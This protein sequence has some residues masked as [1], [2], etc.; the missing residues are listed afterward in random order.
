MFDVIIRKFQKYQNPPVC[1]FSQGCVVVVC[2]PAH[3]LNGQGSCPDPIVG[4]AVVPGRVL[5]QVQVFP[6][7][8]EGCLKNVRIMLKYVIAT[9][10]FICCLQMSPINNNACTWQAFGA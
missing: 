1:E 6:L 9:F 2:L 10:H 5:R 4:V 3:L 8:L 7:V